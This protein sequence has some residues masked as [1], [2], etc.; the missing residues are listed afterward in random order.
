MKKRK[1]R[2]RKERNPG[3]FQKGHD[4]RRHSGFTKEQCR[5]GYRSAKAKCDQ[6]IQTAAW[7]WRL[8]RAHY[9]AKGM[10]YPQSERR[11]HGE[12]E[13]R[14]GGSSADLDDIPY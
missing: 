4:P 5:K 3:W 6:D 8:I 12:E 14:A 13:R 11:K 9:R 1:K 10:W 7:F 2:R